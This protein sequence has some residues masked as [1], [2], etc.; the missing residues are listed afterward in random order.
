[1]VKVVKT[2]VEI[3][4]EVH[5]ETV[6]VDG[7]EPQPWG[8]EHEFA[9]VGKPASRVDGRA[10]VTGAARY[11]YDAHPPGL[12]QAVVLRC[13]YPHARLLSLD[14]SEAEK[15]PGVRAVLSG[16]NAPDI[17]WYGGR[18][19]LFGDELRFAGE[20]VAAVAADDLETARDALGLIKVEYEPLPFVTGVEEAVKPG[21]P[22]V[23][24]DGNILQSDRQESEVY[25]RGDIER[26]LKVADVV[27]EA[28]YRTPAALH[29]SFEA[30]GSVAAWEGDELTVWSSTQYIFGVRD[31][32]A[33]ALNMPLS[34]IRVISE[35]MGGGFGSKGQT[36]K[37]PVIAALLARMSGRPVKLMMD[38]REENLLTGNR[39]AT[40]QR[41]RIGAK[42]D[43]TLC[44]IELEVLYNMGAYGTWAGV[45]DGP[46]KEL[47]LCPNVRTSTKG[48]RTNLGTH[49]AFRAPGFV[50]GM[51]GLESAVDE[52][53]VKLEM[54]PLE[55]RRKNHASKDQ[56]SGQDYTSKYL[57]EAYDRV[58]ELMD[59][60]KGAPLPA[61]GALGSE[62]AWQRGI[63]IASQTWSGGGGPPA[64]AYVRLN[65]DGSVEVMCATQDIGTGTKTA[66]SQIAAEELGVPLEQVRFRLG[67]TEKGP[68]NPA[69]WGS[70]TMPSVGPAV[71]GAA[72]DARRQLLDIASYFMEAPAHSLQVKDGKITVENR[73]Q[74]ARSIPD[75]LSE[76]GD[77]MITGKGFR[78][79]NPPQPLR[80]WGAQI[81]QVAVNTATGQVRVERVAAVHDVG[82]VIN[83]M[84]LRSQFYG[85]ILQGIGFG[86]TEERVVD[87]N[88]G[89]VLNP[90]LEEYKI[91]TI[92]DTPL[93]MAEGVDIPD[94]LANHIG[95]KGAGEPPIIPTAPAIVNAI[96]NATRVRMRT[97]PVTPRRL[98]DAIAEQQRESGAGHD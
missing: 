59:L 97:I 56:V 53:C 26:G 20:E 63:G 89:I 10:R 85:G 51:F 23:Q 50:E 32:V 40:V 83:P 37:D 48:V 81:A 93:M 2:K 18:S 58:M 12:I 33:K 67:D 3:E 25:K 22:Q 8:P 46:A 35:Y 47:Y 1:M 76:I 98:L 73:P 82:R 52:L 55:F 28:T 92:A 36:L 14:T 44:A 61:P 65:S 69:S 96:Y 7:A 19:K 87:A 77:Y 11:T 75:I 54:D 64:H 45:V 16:N 95:S 90:N 91:A 6:V 78:G 15:L 43:G 38:R 13:P 17:A 49:S 24:P 9:V 27:I 5:E 71:R 62:G 74:S 86:L 21:A 29:N 66:L 41:Y 88:S 94:T 57:L 80:T 84:G 72:Q 42:R 79:P 39:G 4:G 70:I 68:F 34:K 30:H 31:R 60:E